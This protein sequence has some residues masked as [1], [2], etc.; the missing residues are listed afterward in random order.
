MILS[1]NIKTILCLWTI[2][3]FIGLLIIPYPKSKRG[4]L[5]QCIYL[6]PLCWIFVPLL[7]LFYWAFPR[8][9]NE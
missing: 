4:A 6:G 7:G 5:V 8:K 9:N 1:D 2:I 3:G